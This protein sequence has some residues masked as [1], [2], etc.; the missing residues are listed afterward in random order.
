MDVNE[1]LIDHLARLARLEFAPEEK[2]AMVNDMEKIIGFVEK[3]NELDT[4]GVDP[5]RYM[6]SQPDVYREDQSGGM[7]SPAEA[8]QSAPHHNNDFFKVP[9]VIRKENQ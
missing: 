6:G 2:A 8:L 4:T 5:V 7:V 9:K 1:S 3:L